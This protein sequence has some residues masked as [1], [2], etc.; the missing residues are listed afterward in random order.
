M[1]TRTTVWQ[2]W[3]LLPVVVYVA[4]LTTLYLK[5]GHEYYNQLADNRM[6]REG[7]SQCNIA[8]LGTQGWRYPP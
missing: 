5:T 2:S 7:A 3:S 1:V 4:S 8:L 6:V